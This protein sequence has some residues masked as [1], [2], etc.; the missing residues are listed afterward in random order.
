MIATSRSLPSDRGSDH[1][2]RPRLRWTA[3]V[4][5]LLAL[6]PMTAVVA[7][8]ATPAAAAPTC[9]CTLFA[10]SATPTTVD[11][12]D[13]KAV[14]VGVQFSSSE[15][16][17]I[18][19]VRFFKA[20]A[21]TGIHV[22]SLWTSSGTLLAQATFSNETGTGWQQVD[23]SQPVAVTANTVYVAGYHTNTGHYSQDENFFGPGGLTNDPLSAPGSDSATPNGVFT[24]SDTPVFPSSTFNASNYWVDVVFSP[25]APPPTPPATSLFG[26]NT[27]PTILDSNDP[28]AVEL[29][30][31]FS[32]ATS[33]FVDGIRFFK[34]DAN[35]GE[36]IGSLWTSDGTLLAQA[37]FT[38][39]TADGWQEVDFSQPVPVTPNTLYVAGYHTDTGH[40]SLDNNY[41][42]AGGYTNAPLSAPGSDSATPNDVFTYS[43]TPV[44]PTSTFN[45]SNYWV[46][47][48]FNPTPQPVSIT[49]KTVQSSLPR[50][51]SEP[52]TATEAFS[53]GST[54][55][56]TS[57]ATW[58]SSNPAKVSVSAAG[59]IT[60][61]ANGSATITASLS[62][63]S[64]SV[65][66]QAVSPVAFVLVTPMIAVL[67][68]GQTKQFTATA[69][70][71]DGSHL[72]VTN[73][74][75][76]KALCPGVTVSA[77][78]L[79]TAVRPSVNV[80]TA[81]VGRAVGVSLV[82]VT[83]APSPWRY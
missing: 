54:K 69:F 5:V 68:V 35:T 3:I 36:H 18:S 34:A 57:Q 31:Q 14:E 53:D 21:N 50:G 16:G 41:F 72:D 76:W 48:A 1:R 62:G 82:A 55:D 10:A 67:Q 24:Y 20:A 13:P 17:F 28:Q 27:T 22:G 65:A 44:F 42:T 26:P 78:G 49:V 29:G 40:Y 59:V 23:F 63:L 64:G 11:S 52:A 19:G 37:T 25:T 47:V 33:G 81:T 60:A 15:N 75:A 51:I 12:N 70:L 9:P 32:S 45:G 66:I 30:V 58:T 73:L 61:V 7:L 39:E 8:G 6:V 71:T 79:V 38:N 83:P 43:P 77:T 74:A 46:D 2:H 80:V 4:S 56:V